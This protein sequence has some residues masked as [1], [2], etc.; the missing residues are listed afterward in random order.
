MKA[1]KTGKWT[2][3]LCPFQ[4]LTVSNGVILRDHR[5]IIPDSQQKKVVDIW[6]SSH[7]GI[8]KTKQL[9]CETA[10]FP[11][12]DKIAEKT[13]KTCIPC[14]ASV[15][16]SP[17]CEPLRISDLSSGPWVEVAVD[18]SGYFCTGDWPPARCSRRIQLF[19]WSWCCELNHIQNIHTTS[20]YNFCLPWHSRSRQN[21][22]WKQLHDICKRFCLPS[23]ENYLPLARS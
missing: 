8:V 22:Q 2:N 7:Q 11:G 21:R 16:T 23:L 6:H 10:W 14:Q 1:I 19:S 9:I 18:F 17:S 20:R 13:V 3:W 15:P 4:R 5:L 12:I